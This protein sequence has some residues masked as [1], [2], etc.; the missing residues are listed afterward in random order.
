MVEIV[1]MFFAR[2]LMLVFE[3]LYF[4]YNLLKLSF[5]QDKKFNQYVLGCNLHACNLSWAN[6]SRIS[7]APSPISSLQTRYL[8]LTMPYE[9]TTATA[10]V[11]QPQKIQLLEPTTQRSFDRPTTTRWCCSCLWRS[12]LWPRYL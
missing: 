7:P 1:T 4:F 11:M 8:P 10:P 5:L 2:N 12:W 9:K 3:L 6:N